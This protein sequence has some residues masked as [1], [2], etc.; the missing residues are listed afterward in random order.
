MADDGG[1]ADGGGA[2]RRGRLR[3]PLLADGQPAFRWWLPLPG[4]GLALLWA[5]YAAVTAEGDAA[6]AFLAQLAWPGAAVVAAGA[7]VAW[8]GWRL[9]LD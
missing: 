3:S 5:L 2:E 9:D 8:L 6:R 1:G 7:A 4:A